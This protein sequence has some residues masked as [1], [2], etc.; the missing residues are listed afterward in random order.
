LPEEGLNAL[1]KNYFVGLRI[2]DHTRYLLGGYATQMFADLGA[3][4]IKIEDTGAGDFCRTEEPMRND[5]SHYFSALNR[6]KK[7]VTMNLKT[8][9]GK[10]AY[11][12]LVKTA[13]VVIENFRPGGTK[14]LGIDYEAEKAVKPNIIHC[15]MSSFGQNAPRSLKALHDINFQALSGYLSLNGGKI[16]PIHFVDVSTGMAATQNIFTALLQRDFTGEGAFCDVRMFDS[17]VWWNALIDARYDFYGGHVTPDTLDFP[18]LSYNVYATKDGGSISIAMLEEKFWASFLQALGRED[19]LPYKRCRRQ[20][21]PGAF[22]EMERIFKERTTADW[23][24]F[25]A[26][27]DICAMPSLSKQEAIEAIVA[28]D[29]GLIKY[30]EFPRTGKTLQ[31]RIP[32]CVSSVP[33]CLDWAVQCPLLGEDNNSVFESVG[34]SADEIRA[35]TENGVI[36][37]KKA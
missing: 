32:I 12:R 18:A 34:Y 2:L 24:L 9:A 10:E 35:M 11:F 30:M 3:E 31:T 17:F 37:T 23:K 33:V 27:K 5:V 25:L 20:E 19:L 6:N 8:D 21:A 28:S 15:A 16:S 7:S 13:D 14:R 26:D 4:V 22:E 36:G 1:K 29:T